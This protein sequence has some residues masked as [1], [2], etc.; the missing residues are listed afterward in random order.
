[1]TNERSELFSLPQDAA[2]DLA[3]DC[4]YL[5]DNLSCSILRTKRCDGYSCSFRRTHEQSDVSNQTVTKMLN[6]LSV[7]QQKKIAS[8]YYGGKMPWRTCA[9]SNK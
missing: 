1:M 9:K 4:I 8:S 5:N 7:E 2:F 6:S 3:P